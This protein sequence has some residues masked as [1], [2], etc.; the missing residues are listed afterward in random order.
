MLTAEQ[1]F[2]TVA[3]I[4]ESAKLSKQ[5]HIALD[6]CLALI[7]KAVLASLNKEVDVKNNENIGPTVNPE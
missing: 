3:S 4:C 5:D 7:H 6:K 1:A 2:K